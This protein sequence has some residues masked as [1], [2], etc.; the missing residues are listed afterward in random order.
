MGMLADFLK[1]KT[2]ESTTKTPNGANKKTRLFEKKSTDASVVTSQPA[3]VDLNKFDISSEDLEKIKSSVVEI[4]TSG[5]NRKQIVIGMYGSIKNPKTGK[6]FVIPG[7]DYTTE[8]YTYRYAEMMRT[9]VN[10]P[11]DFIKIMNWE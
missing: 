11:Q 10:R 7:V 6:R 4:D 5:K 8:E 3:S 2:N 9:L 1:A